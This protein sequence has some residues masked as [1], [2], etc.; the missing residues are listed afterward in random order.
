MFV[1][2]SYE[3]QSNNWVYF[4]DFKVTHTKSNV[5]QYNE[6]YP[7]DMNTANSWTRENTTGNNFFIMRVASWTR[8][9]VITKCFLESTILL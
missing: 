8:L 5:I 7:F 9:Q 4:D 1:Y 6:Y 3:N 2:L